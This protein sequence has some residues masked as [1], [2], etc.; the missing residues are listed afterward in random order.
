MAAAGCP[1]RRKARSAFGACVRGE[2]GASARRPATRQA[3][4]LQAPGRAGRQPAP[5]HPR[6]RSEPSE[7]ARSE[8]ER[9]RRARRWQEAKTEAN[10]AGGRCRHA[11]PTV[12]VH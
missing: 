8:R 12:H 2:R 5:A 10:K 3:G 9:A 4:S 11:R 6:H 7:R 1:A